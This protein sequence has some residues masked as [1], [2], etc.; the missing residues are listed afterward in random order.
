MSTSTSTLSQTLVVDN[1]KYDT[2]M[3]T[4]QNMC[5]WRSIHWSFRHFVCN[6]HR[7]VLW[8]GGIAWHTSVLKA[9][10]CRH[11]RKYYTILVSP[12]CN[13]FA[14]I[15]CTHVHTVQRGA[16]LHT[17]YFCRWCVVSN[18]VGST[19][20]ILKY[21]RASPFRRSHFNL[22]FNKF[23]DASSALHFCISLQ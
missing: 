15:N 13:P 2:K 17:I 12:E 10:L 1:W 6:E 16:Q 21:S 19:F 11:C 18:P 14:C 8:R 22:L 9:S 5:S 3:P 7:M 4:K 23:K 20:F